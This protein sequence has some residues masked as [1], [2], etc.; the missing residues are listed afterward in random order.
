MVVYIIVFGNDATDLEMQNAAIY[1]S[2]FSVQF[3]DVFLYSTASAIQK[4]FILQFYTYFISI[5]YILSTS[6]PFVVF[7]AD[8]LE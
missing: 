3:E 4:S 8:H 7:S 1:G 2:K 6:S 5:L